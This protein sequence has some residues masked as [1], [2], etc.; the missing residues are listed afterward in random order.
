MY[1]LR[2]FILYRHLL[3][4]CPLLS[5]YVTL[6]I[7]WN[8]FGP[9]W[10]VNYYIWNQKFISN[11]SAIVL[12]TKSQTSKCYACHPTISRYRRC[13]FPQVLCGIPIM[14]PYHILL[15]IGPTCRHG[16]DNHSWLWRCAARNA[17]DPPQY[18]T[19]LIHNHPACK[20]Y[21][22]KCINCI[23]LPNACSNPKSL[24]WRFDTYQKRYENFCPGV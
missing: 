13:F 4:N 14:A 8:I 7:K 5:C 10:S 9:R 23:K 17:F 19:P 11:V 24:V 16:E 21:I 2:R 6:C 18:Q 12:N 15:S 22:V 3:I 1:A 20:W